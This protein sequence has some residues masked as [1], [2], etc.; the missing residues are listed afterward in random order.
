MVQERFESLA[1][2]PPWIRYE[3]RA[4]YD[5]VAQHVAGRVVVDCA[6]GDGTGSSIFAGAGAAAVRGFDVSAEAVELARA[7]HPG[8]QFTQATA[9]D[10]PAP[11]GSADVFVSLETIEHIESGGVGVLAFMEEVARVLKPNGVFICST[12]NRAVYNPGKPPNAKPW[13]RFHV[14]EFDREEFTAMLRRTFATVRI[15]GQNPRSP[16]VA[17]VLTIIGT[18]P[19]HLAVRCAQAT[20]LAFAP[21]DRASNHRVVPADTNTL[22]EYLVA[23]CTEP[24]L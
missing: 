11:A 21:F 18:L 3:H 10:L 5:F 1:W 8:V 16:A 9:V 14:R 4:R 6:S 7:R 12:P 20:K 23:V 17:R 19:G 13:N 24:K 22:Y 15:F 2:V